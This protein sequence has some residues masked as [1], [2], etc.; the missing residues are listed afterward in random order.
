M[1]I[2]KYEI[3][4]P[5]HWFTQEQQ[6]RLHEILVARTGNP[7]IARDAGRYATSSEGLG[8]TKQYVLGLISPT[9]S[10]S[11]IEKIHALIS[12]GAEVSAKKIGKN[13]VEITAVPRPGVH[14]KPYQCEN[15]GGF[16]ESRG[17]IIHRQIRPNRS[18]FLRA[19]R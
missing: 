12:R 7:N 16:L 14:E 10:I 8:A 19:Q 1:G 13:Q 2:A 18:S 4:D 6:D 17:T 9:R 3:E 5:A 11:L 15:R